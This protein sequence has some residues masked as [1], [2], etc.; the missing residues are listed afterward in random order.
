MAVLSVGYTD[1]SV[2]KVGFG[3]LRYQKLLSLLVERHESLLL[4]FQAR[5]YINS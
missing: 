1:M 3:S 5:W 4:G 2:I